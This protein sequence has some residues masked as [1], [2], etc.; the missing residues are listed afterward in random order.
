MNFYVD[1]RDQ[2]LARFQNRS[3]SKHTLAI[4]RSRT[5]IST[6][7]ARVADNTTT[8]KA[9]VALK[10]FEFFSI[11]NWSVPAEQR[12]G[13]GVIFNSSLRHH[14]MIVVQS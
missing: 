11:Q 10:N 6:S 9:V 1:W 12:I 8:T 4:L 13:G 3:P 14:G 2:G 5:P 7:N